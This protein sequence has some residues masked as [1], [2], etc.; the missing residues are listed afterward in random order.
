MEDYLRHNKSFS[1]Q[2]HVLVERSPDDLTKPRVRLIRS[3][4]VSVQDVQNTLQCVNVRDKGKQNQ[5]CKCCAATVNYYHT[6]EPVMLLISTS[7]NWWFVTALQCCGKLSRNHSWNIDV[8]IWRLKSVSHLFQFSAFYLLVFKSVLFFCRAAIVS[9]L[10]TYSAFLPISNWLN[11]M[12]ILAFF[13][14][15]GKPT[16]IHTALSILHISSHNSVRLH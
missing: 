11:F 8:W 2:K 9:S 15:I 7:F 12:N 5:A 13:S 16:D 1:F 14:L 6:E 4:C 3:V 10:L